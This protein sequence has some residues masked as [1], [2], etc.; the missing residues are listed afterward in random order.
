MGYIIQST[1]MG[2]WKNRVLRKKGK[3]KQETGKSKGIIASPLAKYMCRHN[4]S[5][6]H[7]LYNV[8]ME[9]LIGDKV[10]KK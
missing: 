4:R 5:W 2:M 7:P 1:K 3:G 9:K 8:V 10:R 6:K